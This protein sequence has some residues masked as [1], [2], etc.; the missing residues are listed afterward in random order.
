MAVWLLPA[1]KVIGPHIATII[2]A[3]KPVFTNRGADKETNLTVLLQQQISELQTAASR[4][5][6]NTKELA[7]Q[8]QETVKAFE[9]AAEVAQLKLQKAFKL[10]IA[11]AVLSVVAVLVAL[12][13]VFIR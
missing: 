7:A 3:A 5:A 1:L 11:A 2:A 4:N 9:Q 13:A 6:E 12:F 8:L 10:N